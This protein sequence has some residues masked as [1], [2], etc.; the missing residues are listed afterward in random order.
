M[1][2]RFG[3]RTRPSLYVGQYFNSGA[4]WTGPW[5]NSVAT[6]GTTT[7]YTQDGLTYKSHK[8]TSSGTFTVTSIGTSPTFDIFVQGGGGGGGG[9]GLGRGFGDGSG[10][11]GGF[12]Q[13]TMALPVAAQQVTVGAQGNAAGNAGGQSSFGALTTSVIANGGAGGSGCEYCYGAG[14][15]GG[16][17]SVPGALGTLNVTLTGTTG[18][19]GGSGC[20]NGFSGR[21]QAYE[22]GVNQLYGT[23]FSGSQQGCS[24]SQSATALGGGGQGGHTNCGTGGNGAPGVVVIRY[25]FIA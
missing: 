16:T 17:A 23:T 20:S 15:A 18:P 8:F 7:T 19:A 10:G 4:A 2:G 25:R 6:G 11:A 24:C 5:T 13:T 9:T 22:T 3:Q 21:E 1:S 12:A 14:G